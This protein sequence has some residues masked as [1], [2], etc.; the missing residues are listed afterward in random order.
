MQYQR[1]PRV[2]QSPQNDISYEAVV[3]YY[4]RPTTLALGG[5]GFFSMT[6]QPTP[7]ASPTDNI[8]PVGHFGSMLNLTMT[9]Q[10]PKIKSHSC[11]DL[12]G[13]DKESTL[14]KIR[15][16]KEGDN[17]FVQLLS[18]KNCPKLLLTFP[19]MT[20]DPEVS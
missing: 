15:R 3:I 19:S 6:P 16:K 4:R 10:Q 1:I 5:S 18:S 7:L 20:D 8:H 11:T 14:R 17:Q 2:S 13:G 12:A 9:C